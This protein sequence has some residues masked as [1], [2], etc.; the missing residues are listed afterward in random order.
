M[1]HPD[2]VLDT[3]EKDTQRGRGCG[4]IQPGEFKT[5]TQLPREKSKTPRHKIRGAQERRWVHQRATQ[6]YTIKSP[7][8]TL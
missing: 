6:R 8:V 7:Y 1:T 2:T 4:R 3:E 5:P